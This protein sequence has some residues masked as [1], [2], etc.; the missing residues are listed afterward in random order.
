I[1]VQHLPEP[2]YVTHMHRLIEAVVTLHLIDGFLGYLNLAPG[3]AC[4]PALRHC[5]FELQYLA[6]HGATG[7]EM[8]DYEYRQGDAEEC[9]Y[10]Q[11]KTTNKI[12]CHRD[13]VDSYS[14]SGCVF[15]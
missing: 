7:N 1:E 8:H 9:R 12:S 4:S 14:I 11:Q 6:F 13:E 2:L 3:C 5:H 15:A 10:D